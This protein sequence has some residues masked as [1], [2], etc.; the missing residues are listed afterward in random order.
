[1][2]VKTEDE[3]LH[4]D[5]AEGEDWKENFATKKALLEQLKAVTNE[6]GSVEKIEEIKELKTELIKNKE[7]G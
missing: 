5:K 4:K 2:K 6:E 3:G 7:E 1:M